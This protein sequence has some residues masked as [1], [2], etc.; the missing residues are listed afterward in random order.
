MPLPK[1]GSQQAPGPPTTTEVNLALEP[2]LALPKPDL[3]GP[4]LEQNLEQSLAQDSPLLN[5]ALEPNLELNL[6][7]YLALD[8]QPFYLSLETNLAQ[9]KPVLVSQHITLAL[10]PCLALFNPQ[11]IQQEPNLANL[12]NAWPSHKGS[13]GGIR[14]RK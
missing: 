12:F 2:D 7:Q 3:P 13:G 8:S 9:S 1:V 6:V 5:L 11:G 14:R 4:G 10:E